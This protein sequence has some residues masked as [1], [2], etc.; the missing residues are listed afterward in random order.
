M[1]G[2]ISTHY[3]ELFGAWVGLLGFLQIVVRI[4]PNQDDDRWVAKLGGWTQTVRDLLSFKSPSAPT[5]D[6]G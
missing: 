6:Q 2:W 3:M 5:R 1:L 4:T